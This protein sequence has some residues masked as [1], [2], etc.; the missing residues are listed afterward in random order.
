MAIIKIT[1]ANTLLAKV[2]VFIYKD[3]AYFEYAQYVDDLRLIV[4][5]IKVIKILDV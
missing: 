1:F 5:H 2:T 3:V 4:L